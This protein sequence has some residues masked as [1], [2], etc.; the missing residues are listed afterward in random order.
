[1]NSYRIKYENFELQVRNSAAVLEK[2]LVFRSSQN[3]KDCWRSFRHGLSTAESLDSNILCPIFECLSEYCRQMSPLI[4]KCYQAF[5][6]NRHS[7][8][9]DDPQ[10]VNVQE[11]FPKPM[12]VCVCFVIASKTLA[13]Q[14]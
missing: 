6:Q 10:Q 13:R 7:A 4:D 5:I 3:I 8:T 12:S 11:F 2:N 9:S 14:T 1:M